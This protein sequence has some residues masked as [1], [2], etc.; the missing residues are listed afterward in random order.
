MHRESPV[1]LPIKLD[2]RDLSVWL[3]GKN[4][5]LSEKP[6]ELPRKLDKIA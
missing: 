1:R 3:A 5:F 6:N 4:P 2:I